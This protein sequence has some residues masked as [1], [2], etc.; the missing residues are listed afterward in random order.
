ML[1]WSYSEVPLLGGVR[2]GFFFVL[3]LAP[4]VSD[5]KQSVGLARADSASTGRAVVS[6]EAS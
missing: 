4:F 1:L 3:I 5:P 6:W 2:G